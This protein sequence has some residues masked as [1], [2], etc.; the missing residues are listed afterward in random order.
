MARLHGTFKD[1]ACVHL[2]SRVFTLH[3]RVECLKHDKNKLSEQLDQ[4]KK[5]HKRTLAQKRH[6]EDKADD[7]EETAKKIKRELTDALVPGYQRARDD[8]YMRKLLERH[9]K[10]LRRFNLTPEEYAALD[11]AEQETLASQQTAG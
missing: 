2:I 3:N 10:R 6:F 8:D 4:L 5:M 1:E 11:A 9:S 7:R